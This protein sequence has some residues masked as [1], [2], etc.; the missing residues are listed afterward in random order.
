VEKTIMIPGTLSVQT[1]GNDVWDAIVVGAG[2]AGAVAARQLALSGSRVLLVDAKAFPRGKCCGACLNSRALAVLSELGLQDAV[3]SLGG[4]PIGNFHIRSAGREVH[5]P[6]PKGLAIS[7]L[8]LDAALV[9]AAMTAG[10]DFLP[11]TTAIVG[12]TCGGP[13]DGCRVVSLRSSTAGATSGAILARGRVVVVADGLGHASLRNHPEFDSQVSADAHIGVGGQLPQA[14]PEYGGGTIFMAIG[15]DGYVGLVRIENGGLNIAGALA[16]A[17]M[18][19]AGGTGPAIQSILAQAGFPA[20]PG[21][22]QIDWLG[23][24]PLT[25][26]STH[27]SGER[28]L[29]LGDA[30]GYVEPFTGEGMAWAFAAAASVAP[31]VAS[32]VTAWNREIEREWRHNLK[33][34]VTRRQRWCRWLAFGLR[35]PWLVRL[36]LQAVSWMPPLARPIIASVNRPSVRSGRL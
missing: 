3:E 5:L 25:R 24:L 4:E 10:V 23:T 2:P 29:L 16:P 27:S 14:P 35:R 26:H 32:G 8:R 18:K 21:L 7:R 17:F 13:S 36:L 11:E 19:A 20:I 28:V 6:L 15:R 1:A 34:L 31:F 9:T 12:Q 22:L 30:A 33:N